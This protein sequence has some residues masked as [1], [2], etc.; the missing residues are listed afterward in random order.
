M[1]RQVVRAAVQAPA[2]QGWPAPPQAPQA[3]PW[4]TPPPLPQVAPAATQAPPSFTPART[5]Q[6]APQRLP[7]Q[8]GWPGCPQAWHTRGGGISSGSDVPTG[9]S[10]TAAHSASPS[11]SQGGRPGSKQQLCPFCPQPAQRPCWQ[12][13]AGPDGD[14]QVAPVATQAPPAQQPP[15][16]HATAPGPAGQQGCPFC[17]QPRHTRGAGS[18]EPAGAAPSGTQAIPAAHGRSRQ[19]G[20]PAP[21][22]GETQVADAK[23]QVTPAPSQGARPGWA[24]QACPRPPQRSQ[25]PPSQRPP[26]P[27][28]APP[29]RQRPAL[30]QPPP[31]QAPPEQQACPGS[32]QGKQRPLPPQAV[33]AARQPPPGQHS[34]P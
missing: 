7:G 20:C 8:Q 27:Q 12:V 1:S 15:S 16:A 17:P 31:L 11:L 5:Q 4:H 32:P 21:P 13:P 22:Q 10:P 2:Q 26:A 34:C 29:A 25:R 23:S 28:L 9:V 24:Q 19:Q 6:P 33:S 30:Q 3:P 14:G 18:P